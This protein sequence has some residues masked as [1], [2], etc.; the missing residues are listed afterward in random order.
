[1]ISLAPGNRAAV[2]LSLAALVM[3]ASACGSSPTK[4]AAPEDG[5]DPMPNLD[6]GTGRAWQARP[7][8]VQTVRLLTPGLRQGDT[9]RIQ[10]TLK[11]ISNQPVTINRLVCEVDIQTTMELEGPFIHCVIGVLESSLAPGEEDTRTVSRKV[12]A[13]PGRYTVS[14]R[15]ILEPDVWVT[16]DLTIHPRS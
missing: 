9:L 4:A 15:H 12:L 7:S 6:G 5:G 16:A 13:P 2:T 14:I 3:L 11:N 1:M 8:I 10:S